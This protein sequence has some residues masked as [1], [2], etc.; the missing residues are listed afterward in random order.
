MKESKHKK[1][2]QWRQILKTLR[3][4]SKKLMAVISTPEKE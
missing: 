4:D 2:K 1:S 3:Y